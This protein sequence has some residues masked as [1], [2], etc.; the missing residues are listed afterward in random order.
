LNIDAHWS[1]AFYKCLDYIQLKDGEDKVILNRDDAAGFKL[2][3]TYT[4]KQHKILAEASNPELTTRTDYVNKYASVLQT[5][6]YLFMGT[7]N[8]AETALV[9][10]K[11][12]RCFL[13][14][15]TQP[16]MLQILKVCTT[17]QIYSLFCSKRM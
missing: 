2:D 7:E 14:I 15:K 10:S 17:I 4:H 12:T 1:C 3:T 11:H 16:N 5:T 6:S 8:T 9:L 13:N